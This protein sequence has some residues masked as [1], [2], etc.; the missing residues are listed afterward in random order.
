MGNSNY[1]DRN[2]NAG[3]NENNDGDTSHDNGW[4]E[5]DIYID[6]EDNNTTNYI[7]NHYYYYRYK[8]VKSTMM[9]TTKIE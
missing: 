3:M 8:T 9:K 5:C 6:N 4:F 7:D 1:D 2:V